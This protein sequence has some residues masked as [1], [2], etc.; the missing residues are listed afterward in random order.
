MRREKKR[1]VDDRRISYR[2]LIWTAI[3]VLSLV[4]AACIAI[5]INPNLNTNTIAQ[6]LTDDWGT[7][8]NN[9]GRSGYDGLEVLKPTVASKLKL[10]WSYQEG[11]PISTQ[12][13]VVNGRI[14]WGSWDGY[15]H[16]SDLKGKEVWRTNLG[17]T[18][19]GS[20]CQP[21]SVGVASTATLT[22]VSIE[23]K[24]ISAV[25]V[26]GGDAHFYALDATSG[27]V[28]WKTA[29]GTSSN[30][31]IWSS[32]AVYEGSIYIGLASFAD[33]P[34]VQGKFFQLDATTGAILHTFDVV[35]AGCIGGTIWGSAAIDEAEGV[36]YIGTS[37]HGPC[38]KPQPEPYVLALLEFRAS[39]LQLLGTW[40]IPAP[41]QTDNG[42][43]GSTPTLFQAMIGGV[44]QNMVG[45]L[46]KNGTYYAFQR[47]ALVKGPVWS[48]TLAAPAECPQCGDGNVS[49]GAWDGTH[50]YVA[51]GPIPLGGE[52]C[53]AS[54]RELDPATGVSIWEQCLKVGPVLGAVTAT[55][56]MLIVG[57]GAHLLVVASDTGHTLFDYTDTNQG[58]VFYGAA[59][60]SLGVIYIGSADGMLYAFGS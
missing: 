42:D 23:K 26:G 5:N 21:S 28:L 8:L 57:E 29:L 38:K 36:L 31:F 34:L 58:A 52:K 49:P 41:L 2:L 18:T 4:G 10:H 12:P 22:S 11:S 51:A 32:P 6:A 54:L 45:I 1:W 30:Q 46:N 56:G 60:L 33:C 48:A 20:Y 24:T 37:E 35:P 3:A 16:A 17:K 15:E 14:Y 43:F 13:I 55:P 40:Q 9:N 39:D 27:K 50:L 44:K 7:Y 53:A 19:H 47:D 25:L 59:S